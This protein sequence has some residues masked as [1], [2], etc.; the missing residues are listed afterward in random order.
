MRKLKRDQI[1]FEP[2]RLLGGA[3]ALIT[4]LPFRREAQTNLQIWALPLT[5]FMTGVPRSS[6]C[7]TVLE[8][9]SQRLAEGCRE[10]K[11]HHR[12]GSSVGSQEVILKVLK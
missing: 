6:A 2:R 1:S 8:G 3:S 12:A 7:K 9:A 10:H 4:R 11:E 5:A